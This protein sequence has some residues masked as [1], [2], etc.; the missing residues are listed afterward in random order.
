MVRHFRSVPVALRLAVFAQ[1][2]DVVTFVWAGRAG[3][4]RNPLAS[5]LHQTF[6]GV[7]SDASAGLA[8]WLTAVVVIGLKTALVFYLAWAAPRLGQYQ[9]PVLVLAIAAGLI[10]A[11]SNSPALTDLIPRFG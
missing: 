2:A 9:R 4:D 3:E 5:V 1:V 8:D 7:T 10:G 11:L 6:S